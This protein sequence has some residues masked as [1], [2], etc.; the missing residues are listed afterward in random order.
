MEKDSIKK[1]LQEQPR[2]L[3]SNTCI[4]KST[5]QV[6]Q[7]SLML[8]SQTKEVREVTQYVPIDLACNL[9]LIFSL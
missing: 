5:A 8:T 6:E 4:Y 9:G 3:K 7:D 1:D 2:C